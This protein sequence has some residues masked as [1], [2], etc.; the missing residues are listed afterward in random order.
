MPKITAECDY[1]GAD[2]ECTQWDIDDMFSRCS[3]C[4]SDVCEHCGDVDESLHKSCKESL[5]EEQEAEA[6]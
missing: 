1:C 6:E 3:N 4:A 5:E 2:Y